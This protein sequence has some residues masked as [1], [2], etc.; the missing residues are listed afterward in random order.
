MSDKT[1]LTPENLNKLN[2][3]KVDQMLHPVMGEEF[4]S[5]DSYEGISIGDIVK[6]ADGEG[7][8]VTYINSKSKSPFEVQIAGGYKGN[9]AL[10]ELEKVEKQG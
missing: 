10:D 4:Q 2:S 3:E 8:K 6:T 9:Y 7:G 5:E 1:N